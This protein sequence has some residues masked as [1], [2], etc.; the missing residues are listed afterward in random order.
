M[1][2]LRLRSAVHVKRSRHVALPMGSTAAEDHARAARTCWQLFHNHFELDETAAASGW[3]SV[4]SATFG[5]TPGSIERGGPTIAAAMWAA[6]RGEY[7]RAIKEASEAHE[8]GLSRGD[9]N[10]AAWDWPCWVA[11]TSPGAMSRTAWR[12]SMRR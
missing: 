12:S 4:H 10:L 7:D 3:L 9:R 5:E 8:L 11:C 1:R 6:Y 2:R